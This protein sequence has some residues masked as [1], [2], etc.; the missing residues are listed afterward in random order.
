MDSDTN[1]REIVPPASQYST[2]LPSPNN[3]MGQMGK[4]RT[5]S[6]V[7]DRFSWHGMTKNIE[8]WIHQCP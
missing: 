3:S 7:K 6:L 2:V 4:D 8:R 5:T 1:K